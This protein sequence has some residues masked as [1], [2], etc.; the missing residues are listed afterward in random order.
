MS[1]KTR[2][3]RKRVRS[4]QKNCDVVSHE[5]QAPQTLAGMDGI[6]THV[7]LRVAPRHR[8]RLC[9]L[10]TLDVEKDADFAQAS[11]NPEVLKL[12]SKTRGVIGAAAQ[13]QE[14]TGSFRNVAIALPGDGL[15]FATVFVTA[16]QSVCS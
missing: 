2:S 10:S 5:P 1:E 11:V 8:Q 13:L 4:E 14:A 3:S 16:F 7:I 12:E 15:A 9:R 6:P